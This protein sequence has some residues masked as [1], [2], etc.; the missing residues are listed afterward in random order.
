MA[1]LTPVESRSPRGRLFHAAAFVLLTAGGA[2]MLYPFLVM[3]S[4][5]LRTEIDRTEPGLI[6]GYLVRVEPLQRKFLEFK[7]QQRIVDFNRARQT[8]EFSFR[9]ARVPTQPNRALAERFAAF[10]TEDGLPAHWKVLGGVSAKGSVPRNLRR[11]REAVRERFG[12]D[13]SRFSRESG[14]AIDSWRQFVFPAPDWLSPS[15][16]PPDGEILD[17]YHRVLSASAPSEVILVSLS[18]YFLERMVYPVYPGP[19]AFGEAVGLRLENWDDFRLPSG[20]E[21]RHSPDFREMWTDFVLNELNPSF[22]LLPERLHGRFGEFLEETYGEIDRLNRDWGGAY[23]DFNAVAL[24]RGEYLSGARREAYAS[25]LAEMDPDDFRLVGPEFAWER[26]AAGGSLPAAVAALET[27]YVSDH[28]AELRTRFAWANFADVLEASLTG[29]RAFFN[30]FVVCVLAVLLTLLINPLAAYGL[31]R[32]ALPGS[33]RI[34]LGLMAV[35]AFPPMVTTIPVFLMIRE[36]G[37]L[38]SY[39][40]I[41]LPFVANGYFIFLLK[42]FFDSLPR[43]L[44]EA[45]S[46]DGVSEW[47]MFFRIVVPLSKPVLA[48]VA[49]SAFNAAYSIFLFAMIVA[50]AEDMWLLPVWLYQYQ[51]DASTGG[52][53]ASVLVA[54]VPPI[55]VFLLAQRAILR[56]IVVPEEK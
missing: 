51:T 11:L 4:G 35:M 25:F 52:V 22:V 34:L 19:S 32:F 30:T 54:S 17:A 56:G 36:A 6:P 3:V 18:G 50:P 44:F 37:L 46:I 14:Y 20:L 48:V 24:P 8:R 10:V 28:V 39:A 53:F 15:Y 29:G 27:A 31:S 12:D 1:I 2:T 47:G 7:Y 49:L 5:S 16:Q 41:V 40:A 26:K 45:A 43:E 23:A 9:E 55:L 21:D 33:Y 38:N 42:G 13:F